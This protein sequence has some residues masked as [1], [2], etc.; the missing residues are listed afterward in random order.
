MEISSLRYARHRHLMPGKRLFDMGNLLRIVEIVVVKVR[1][2]SDLSPS[3]NID[4]RAFFIPQWTR[5]L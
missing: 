5:F 4:Y 3:K 1:D 2:P